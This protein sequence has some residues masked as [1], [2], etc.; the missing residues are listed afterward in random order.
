MKHHKI[1]LPVS[2]HHNTEALVQRQWHIFRVV[3][4]FLLDAV[5]CPNCVC[6]KKVLQHWA[7]FN[8]PYGRYRFCRLPF[9]IKS[10]SDVFQK[11][12]NHLFQGYI[13]AK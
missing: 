10:A 13:H 4:S 11:A 9:G 8:T 7:T 5:P 12:T 2:A 6:M 1:E 3:E